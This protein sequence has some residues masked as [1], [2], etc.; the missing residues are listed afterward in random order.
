MIEAHTYWVTDHTTSDDARRYRREEDV[1]PWLERD[2]I[3]RLG[4]FMKKRG[5][6]DE[7][8][9]TAIREEA[10][11]EVAEAVAA[12]EGYDM[13]SPDEIFRHVYAEIT[14]PLDEQ[15]DELKK[16]LAGRKG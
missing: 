16:R 3:T 13:P 8:Q 10:D 12:F 6:L 5:Q 15:R 14:P 4:R 9:E 1:R 11:R 7:T 2:P